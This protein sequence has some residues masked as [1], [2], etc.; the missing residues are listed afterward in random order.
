MAFWQPTRGLIGNQHFARNLKNQGEDKNSNHA[1][2]YF[3]ELLKENVPVSNLN[4]RS[5]VL[6]HFVNIIRVA[7]NATACK[8]AISTGFSFPHANN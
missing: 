1:V 8:F 3:N 5:L 4:A 2:R 6:M 7:K